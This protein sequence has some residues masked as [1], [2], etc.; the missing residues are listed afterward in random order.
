MGLEPTTTGLRAMYFTNGARQVF[1][2]ERSSAP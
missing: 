2:T 1:Y